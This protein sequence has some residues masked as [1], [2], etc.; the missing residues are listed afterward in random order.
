[1]S[2]SNSGHDLNTQNSPDLH[3]SILKSTSILSLGTLSSRILGFIRD[4]LL[5]SILGTRVVADAFFVALK[6]PNL[7]R[8]FVAEGAI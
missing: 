3:K 7:F 4:V 2:T 1:M 5:A 8:D 6:I